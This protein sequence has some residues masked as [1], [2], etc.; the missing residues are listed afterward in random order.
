[1]HRHPLPWAK[2][3]SRG[4]CQGYRTICKDGR[5]VYPT[6]EKRGGNIMITLYLSQVEALTLIDILNKVIGMDNDTLEEYGLK[7]PQTIE[8]LERILQRMGQ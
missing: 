8:L 3:Y 7:D 2:A 5:K 1:M 6:H 4:N